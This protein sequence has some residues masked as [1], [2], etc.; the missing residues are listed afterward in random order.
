MLRRELA[1]KFKTI[2]ENISTEPVQLSSKALKTG[3]TDLQ[4]GW[5]LSKPKTGSVRFSE[6]I[7]QYLIY[8]FD[9][10]EKTGEKANLIQVAADM[11][12]ITDND[13]NRY[14][15]REEW[16]TPTKINFSRQA[17][18]QRTGDGEAPQ[19]SP[20]FEEFND[21]YEVEIQKENS[22]FINEILTSIGITHPILYDK[23][24]LCELYHNNRLHNFK[25]SE[26]KQICSYLELETKLTN[27]ENDLIE[28]IKSMVIQC[29][30]VRKTI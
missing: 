30:C 8:K 17:K 28:R 3:K 4:V 9:T 5:A 21:D 22:E 18:L 29:T 25:V 27:R 13:G 23:F 19:N 14:F 26:L 7:R 6:K 24:D 12:T 20:N 16:L 1:K 15:I 2:E 11:R 10:G